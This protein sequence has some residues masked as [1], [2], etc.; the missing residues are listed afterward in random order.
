MRSIIIIGNICSGKTSLINSLNI[1][2]K[3]KAMAIDEYR[4]GVQNKHE[5][6]MVWKNFIELAAITEHAIIESSG[7]SIYYPKLIEAL[8]KAGSKITVIKIT[9]PVSYCIAR[10]HQRAENGLFFSKVFHVVDSVNYIH[11]KLKEVECHIELDGRYD[12]RKQ[13]LATLK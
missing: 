3:W 1:G 7:A 11:E 2:G 4:H 9:I 10:Y 8:Q 12:I 6:A 13:L 5:D